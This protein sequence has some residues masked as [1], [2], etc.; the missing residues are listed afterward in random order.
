MS[1]SQVKIGPKPLAAVQDDNDEDDVSEF[2]GFLTFSTTGEV[3]VPREWL[4]DKWED[5]DLPNS[6]LPKQPSNWSAYR[7]MKNELLEDADY[8]NYQVHLDQY[9]RNFNCKFELEKSDEMGSNT[10][11]VYSKVFFPEELNGEEGG[12]WASKR[13]GHL[14]FYRPNDGDAPG[15]LITNFDENGD[16]GKETVHEEACMRLADRARDLFHKMQSHHN[17]ADM[18][19]IIE[20]FRANSN[21]VAIR[22]AVYFIG[23]HHQ[24]TIESLSR[25]W[26]DLN[27]FKDKGEDMRI[28]TTPVVNI[29]SQR[30]M[31]ASRVREK[32]EELVDDI[33]SESLSQFE[34]DNDMTTDATAREIM[35]QLSET[36]DISDEYN[37]LLSLRLSIKDILEDQ[38]EKLA[39][40]QADIVQ[41]VIEQANLEEYQ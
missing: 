3:L 23:S 20:D 16:G 40:E 19:G 15:Q 13:V 35:D 11:I 41:S 24:D 27:R 36:Y 39:E 32:V 29:E 12:D 8:R 34:D 4:L 38:R 30:E 1:Q 7:R 37:A 22:R 14:E 26:K 2:L 17:Y 10:Y 25:L 33:V 5:Y 21:A 18:N 28:D 31:V 6:L 9:N